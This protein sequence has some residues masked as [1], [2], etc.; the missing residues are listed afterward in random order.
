MKKYFIPQ[1]N[2]V[3]NH[4]TRGSSKSIIDFLDLKKVLNNFALS[5]MSVI[6]RTNRKIDMYH[7]CRLEKCSSISRLFIQFML[8][9]N[10]SGLELIVIFQCNNNLYS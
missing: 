4:E 2:F 8:R 5:H 9:I 10:T 1:L 3:A 6:S 7:Q